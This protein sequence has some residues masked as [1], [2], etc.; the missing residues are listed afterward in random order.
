MAPYKNVPML[1][2]SGVYLKH[3]SRGI[4]FTTKTLCTMTSFYV[5]QWVILNANRMTDEFDPNGSS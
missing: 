3:I 4:H 2:P 1:N 5:S